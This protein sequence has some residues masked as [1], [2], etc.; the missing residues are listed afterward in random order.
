M[1]DSS[2]RLVVISIVNRRVRCAQVL[3]IYNR[4]KRFTIVT[5]VKMTK[6]GWFTW[7]LEFKLEEA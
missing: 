5:D 2:E 7:H 4:N 3:R 1:Q 6:V